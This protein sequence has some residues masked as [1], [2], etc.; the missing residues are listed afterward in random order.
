MQP[1]KLSNYQL[2]A[3]LQDKNVQKNIRIHLQEEFTKR[4][5]TKDELALIEMDWVSKSIPA[6]TISKASLLLKIIIIFAPVLLVRMAPFAWVLAIQVSLATYL[7]LKISR[8]K[9]RYYWVLIF[10]G[11]IFWSI[12]VVV[13][14][15]YVTK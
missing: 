7:V 5:I 6:P 11:Y 3:L 14:A 13:F 1:D 12:I 8:L 9:W 10:S 2:Y 15:K 4:N